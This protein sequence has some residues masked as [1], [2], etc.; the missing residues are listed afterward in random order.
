MQE[1]GISVAVA[2]A[3]VSVTISTYNYLPAGRGFLVGGSLDTSWDRAN[4]SQ[5]FSGLGLGQPLIF[6]VTLAKCCWSSAFV[7]MWL[8]RGLTMAMGFIRKEHHSRRPQSV[9]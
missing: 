5:G 8:Q 3:R 9:S 7:F 2:V 1:L 4:R 6:R